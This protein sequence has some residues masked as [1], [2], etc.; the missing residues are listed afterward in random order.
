[1]LLQLK[2]NGGTRLSRLD[3]LFVDPWNGH[4]FRNV[5]L[6]DVNEDRGIY[7]FKLS[8]SLLRAHAGTLYDGDAYCAL[9]KGNPTLILINGYDDDIGEQYATIIEGRTMVAMKDFA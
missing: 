1:M 9:C 8:P 2:L 5:Y 7:R 4:V 3:E 6:V